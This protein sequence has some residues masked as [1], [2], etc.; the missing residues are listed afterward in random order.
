MIDIDGITDAMTA[1]S[2]APPPNPKAADT[3]EVRKLIRHSVTKDQ[4]ETPGALA[5]IS[6]IMNMD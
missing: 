1:T 4:S 6:Y 2:A 5:R 3:A